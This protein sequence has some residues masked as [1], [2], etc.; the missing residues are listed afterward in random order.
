[1]IFSASRL[2]VARCRRGL[3]K[4]ALAE[5][6][7]HSAQSLTNYEDKARQP[8]TDVVQRLSFALGFP[9]SYFYES[10]LHLVGAET[11]TFRARRSLKSSM[12]D[13]ALATGALATEIIS[14]AIRRRFNLPTV[15][16]PDLGGE[17]PEIAAATLRQS[18]RQGNG[19]IH[20]MVHLLESK[21]IEVYWLDE[22][23]RSLDAFALWRAELPYVLLNSNTTAGDRARFDAAH[24]LGHLVL[25][26]N[27]EDVNTRDVESE[28]HRF[29]SAFLMPAEQFRHE[30]P[31]LPVMSRYYALKQRWG[32]SIQ[33]M[34]RRGY[35]LE[36]FSEWH[37]E[38]SAKQMS[39]AGWRSGTPEPVP[40]SK[41]T[42][43]LHNMVFDML[44]K[45]KI[46]P[47]EWAQELKIPLKDLLE[48]MPGAKDFLPSE[49]AEMPLPP[50][51]SKKNISSETVRLRFG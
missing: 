18:W 44:Q 22:P 3:T 2:T 40:I 7:D 50:E 5:M 45:K 49:K 24:E 32:C 46:S 8:P 48:I 31:R 51:P 35:D 38:Q 16:V 4:R 1:M 41:E 39:S 20:N 26:R 29:A 27:V 12:R 30:S 14:P 47:R 25:H 37:Y 23:D 6:I 36:L 42:S 21:G 11:V 9:P 15:D 10:D 17:K 43:L 33:A 28:A 13:K 34:V 19:P